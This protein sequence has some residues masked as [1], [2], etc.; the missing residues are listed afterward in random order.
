V[1]ALVEQDRLRI[2]ELIERVKLGIATWSAVFLTTR[3]QCR[4]LRRVRR[5]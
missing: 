1:Q 4:V 5:A 2:A 3:T